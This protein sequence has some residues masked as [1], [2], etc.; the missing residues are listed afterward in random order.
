MSDRAVILKKGR[1]KAVRN[2]H[3]W[4]FSG[5]VA[6]L[7]EFE[8][9]EILAVRSSG[10]E[11]LGHAY[12]NPRSSIIGRLLSFGAEPPLEAVEKNIDSALALRRALLDDRTTACRLIHGEGDS[13]P[14]L[15]A[16]KYADV[17]VIQVAT[18][19]MEKL[20]PKIVDWLAEKTRPRSIYEQSR[21]PARREE[22][23][24][25]FEG[26]L[27]GEA[28]GEV[29]IRE[30][31]L[32]FIVQPA[33]SQKTGFFLDLRAMRELVGTLAKGRRLLNCFSYTGAFSVAALAAGAASVDSVEASRPAMDLARRNLL[34]NGFSPKDSSLV[35]GDVFEHLRRLDAPY[36][37][38]IL[39]PPA[40]AKKK[41]DVV[42]ACRG[43]KDINRLALQKI[44]RGGLL[45]TF[46]CSHFVDPGLFQQ[47]VWEAAVEASRRVRILQ[48]HRQAG[49]HPVN[50]F[51]P[52]SEYL[53]GLLLYVE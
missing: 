33:G 44:A 27:L 49:D 34:L 16:D 48:R 13:L 5:A 36:D 35:V 38:I 23:L 9:G 26:W 17:L 29:E 25:D 18:L 39:D 22:G 52:E 19:G 47:V 51:H 11:L 43:Y 45:L 24:A 50:I 21:L 40:F 30:N 4:I 8:P 37:M 31:N 6:S 1:D 10:G 12:F 46:S 53:K 41:A 7:P 32:R 42:R 2:R 3:H 20:K 15:V 14:G 28:I